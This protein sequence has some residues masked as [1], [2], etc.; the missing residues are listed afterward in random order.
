[1]A[2]YLSNA[3][4]AL[5][6][7]FANEMGTLAK[8]LGVDTEAVVRIFM[9]DTRLNISPSYLAPGF[10]FGGS[11]LPKDLRALEYC[12]KELDLQ[13]PLL[14]SILPSNAQHVERAVEAVL[15][16]GTRRIGLLG[17][18]F[19]PGTDDLRESPQVLLAK[20]LIGEGCQLRIWDPCV[21]LGHLVGSNRH[22][23]DEVIPHIGLLLSAEMGDV[24]AASET[25]VIATKSLDKSQVAALLRPEQVV[26]DLVHLEKS[27][28][29]AGGSFYQGLCW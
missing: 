1:M 4:H 24:I 21:S 22:F 25:V 5:K 19:K 6:V 9:S 14:Q 27:L 18:S 2:K 20:R 3:F 17:L 12:A 16:T 28:R 23:I 29:P 15:R 26:I 7:S 8:Q 10:A 11:C 13:L